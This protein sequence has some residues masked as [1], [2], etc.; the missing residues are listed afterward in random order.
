[1]VWVMMS[2][3]VTSVNAADP[4]TAAGIPMQAIMNG[5]RL[6]SPV[7]SLLTADSSKAEILYF[8]F[9][10]GVLKIF[11]FCHSACWVKHMVGK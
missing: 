11:L 10:G 1:M 9:K 5:T 6:R 3:A 2:F 4:A 8:L 7:H